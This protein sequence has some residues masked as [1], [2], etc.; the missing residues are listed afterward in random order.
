MDVRTALRTAPWL[1]LPSAS[2]TMGRSRTETEFVMAEGKKISGSA[3]PVNTPYTL[4]A[5][6]LL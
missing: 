3:I 6:A 2:D 4:S 1:P 5:L